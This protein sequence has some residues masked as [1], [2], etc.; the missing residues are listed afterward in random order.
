MDALHPTEISNPCNSLS[1][2]NENHNAKLTGRKVGNVL[3][4]FHM[5]FQLLQGM[6]Q[7]LLQKTCVGQFQ[8]A[9]KPT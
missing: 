4:T 3:C 2:Q 1:L 6:E 7:R 8:D 5:R 9:G